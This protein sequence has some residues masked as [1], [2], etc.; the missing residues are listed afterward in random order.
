MSLCGYQVKIKLL[1]LSSLKT[2]NI[3]N[4]PENSSDNIHP[5]SS[6]KMIFLVSSAKP[7]F[8]VWKHLSSISR[9]GWPSLH[10]TPLLSEPHRRSLFHH[11][12]SSFQL[13]YS[14]LSLYF[15][16]RAWPIYQS[17]LT[18]HRYI[19]DI[20]ISTYMLPK[21]SITKLFTQHNADKKGLG[22]IHD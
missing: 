15:A 9:A 22:V 4:I 19:W 13:N 16:V 5:L 2:P 11:P 21:M 12:S 3:C 17:I 18:Y 6:K 8:H 7:W 14:L 20:L 1:I 10:E